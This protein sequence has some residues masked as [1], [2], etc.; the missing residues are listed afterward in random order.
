MPMSA[1]GDPKV[2]GP[3]PVSRISSLVGKTDKNPLIRAGYG[4]AKMRA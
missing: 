2:S 1:A 4:S 3:S